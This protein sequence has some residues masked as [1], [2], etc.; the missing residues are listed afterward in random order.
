MVERRVR[1][2]A[3]V[4]VDEVDGPRDLAGRPDDDAVGGG[5]GVER[6]EGPRH[7]HLPPRLEHAVDVARPV[8]V[9]AHGVRQPFDL[10]PL[11]GKRVRRLGV[12]DAVDEDDPEPVEAVEDRHLAVREDRR[13]HRLGLVQR[14]RDR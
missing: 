14:R 6:R 1:R 9:A 5:R 2:L 7:G 10:H 11:A 3:P 12:E 8:D 4:Q 13:G